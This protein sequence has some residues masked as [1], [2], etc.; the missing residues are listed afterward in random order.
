MCSPSLSWSRRSH[1]NCRIPLDTYSH[2]RRMGC[3]RERSCILH[4]RE[5][6]TWLSWGPHCLA[7]CSCSKQASSAGLFAYPYARRPSSSCLGCLAQAPTIAG[8]TGS[9]PVLLGLRNSAVPS[10]SSISGYLL[11]G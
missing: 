9:L 6:P 3:Y 5:R 1:H 8:S 7:F 10:T 2:G 4:L 11:L